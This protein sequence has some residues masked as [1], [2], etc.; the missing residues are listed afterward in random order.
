MNG[1]RKNYQKVC[2][3]VVSEDQFIEMYHIYGLILLLFQYTVLGRPKEHH[4]EIDNE[5][6]LWN[7]FPVFLKHKG[8]VISKRWI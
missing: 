8:F 6:E 7:I 3:I 5:H 2:T 1:K 4:W